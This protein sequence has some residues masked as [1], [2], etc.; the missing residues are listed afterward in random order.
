MTKARRLACWSVGACVLV[1]VLGIGGRVWS[2]ASYHRAIDALN[3]EDYPTAERRLRLLAKLGHSESQYHLGLMYAL[4]WGV[5]RNDEEAIRWFRRAHVDPAHPGDAAA[6]AEYYAGQHFE[7]GLGVSKDPAEA[8]KWYERAAAGG[9]AKA[10][11][12]LA[13]MDDPSR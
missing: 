7:E 8:R 13:V 2:R 10:R 1:S 12:R 3:V 9:F 5:A 6:P 4:G 11:E